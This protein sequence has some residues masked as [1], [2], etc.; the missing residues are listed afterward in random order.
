MKNGKAK[1]VYA[2]MDMNIMG[3][4]VFQNADKIR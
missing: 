4:I 1:Y 3:Q 2:L